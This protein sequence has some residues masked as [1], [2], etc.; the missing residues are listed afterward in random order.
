MLGAREIEYMSRFLPTGAP[1]SAK[2]EREREGEK[3]RRFLSKLE[4][5]HQTHRGIRKEKREAGP[6]RK[7]LSGWMKRSH[8]LRME[9]RVGRNT[10]GITNLS[11][12][13]RSRK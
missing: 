6:G 7:P 13:G 11:E 8:S 12:R 2:R 4:F 5:T 3:E 1:T 10:Q 9:R